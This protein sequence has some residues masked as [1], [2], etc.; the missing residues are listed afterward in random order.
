MIRHKEVFMSL[1]RLL[2]LALGTIFLLLGLVGLLL[3]I[4]PQV[5]FLAASLVCYTGC[6]PG[7]RR[8]MVSTSAYQEYL[9]PYV[10]KY[11][12]LQEIFGE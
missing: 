2:F 7:L 3:P 6:V 9:R 11:R 5:P 10:E 8:W 1:K 4:I 12:L